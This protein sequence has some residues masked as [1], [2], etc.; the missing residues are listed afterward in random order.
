MILTFLQLGLLAFQTWLL[1]KISRSLAVISEVEGRKK[2]LTKAL[3]E[4]ADIA[5]E[6]KK[7]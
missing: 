7:E 4:F 2:E 1:I 5:I 6:L 3:K